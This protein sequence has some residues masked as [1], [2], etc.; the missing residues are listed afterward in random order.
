MSKTFENRHW[1][2]KKFDD[3]VV[4]GKLHFNQYC[5]DEIILSFQQNK[6]NED[7]FYYASELL[8]VEYDYIIADTLDDAMEEFESKIIEYIDNEITM[9]EDMKEKFNEERN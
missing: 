1:E 9:L 3:G 4:V 5:E 7:T 8:S 2:I 6:E